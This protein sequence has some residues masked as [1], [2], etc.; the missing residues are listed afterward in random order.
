ML[1]V[2]AKRRVSKLNKI[3]L[4]AY[5]ISHRISESISVTYSPNRLFNSTTPALVCRGIFIQL[6]RTFQFPFGSVMKA[7]FIP[8]SSPS[9]TTITSVISPNYN[10]SKKRWHIWTANSPGSMPPHSGIFIVQHFPL[11]DLC[12][13]CRPGL[14]VP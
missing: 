7:T 8:I 11:Q 2:I 1:E 9:Q 4:Q 5:L 3:C 14:T 6:C 13:T 10:I 12:D